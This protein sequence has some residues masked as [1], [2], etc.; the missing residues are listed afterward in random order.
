[1]KSIKPGR[2]PSMMGFAGSIFTAIFGVLWTILTISMDAPFIFPIFGICFIAMAIIQ[3]IYNYKNA[4]GRDRYSVFDIVDSEKEPD[5]LNIR[6]NSESTQN[7]SVSSDEIRYCPYCGTRIATDFA[8]CTQ[9][10]KK[11]PDL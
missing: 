3:A 2:G 10:G 7:G 4:S 11:R 6:F 9:C 8:F 5:P 1:M